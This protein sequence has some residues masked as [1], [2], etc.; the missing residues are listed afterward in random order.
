M[1]RSLLSILLAVLFVAGHTVQAQYKNE[2]FSWGLSAGAVQGNNFSSDRWGMQYRAFVQFEVLP[3][4]LTGQA[5]LGLATL[6][7]PGIYSAQTGIADVRLLVT[8]FTMQ[9]MHPYMYVGAAVSKCLNVS[10]TDYLPMFP[11]GL[12]IQTMLTRGTLLDL[13]AGFNLSLS[14]DLDGRTRSLANLN[15]VT[16]Q[17]QDG[18]YGF[19]VGLVFAF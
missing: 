1:K 18:F 17:R 6:W 15:P 11:F 2:P 9:N 10:G 14:D 8:P 19:T 5:G 3:S 4:I 7:A 16:N 13:S 12:G